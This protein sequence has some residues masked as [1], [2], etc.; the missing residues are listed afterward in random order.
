MKKE[1]LKLIIKVCFRGATIVI[2]S[3]ADGN[4]RLV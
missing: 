2:G 4:T 1:D 3:F